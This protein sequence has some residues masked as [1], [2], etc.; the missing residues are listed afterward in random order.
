MTSLERVMTVISGG[1]P[2]RV[3]TGLHNFLMAARIAE[4]PLSECLRDGKLLAE[5]QIAAWRRFGQ[6]ALLVENGTTAVAQ[7]MG[8]GAIYT[9]EAA[10]R[11]IEPVLKRL[12][13]VDSLLVPDPENDAPLP[14]MLEA[15]SI[16]RREFGDSVYIM[17]RADQAPMALA[18][19]LRG[20]GRFFEDLGECSHLPLP[21]E[22][23]Q[24]GVIERI[25]DISLEATIRY[26]LALKKA[27]AH[28]TCIGEFGS[29][30]VSPAMYRQYAV[31]RLRKFF[32]AMRQANF[33]AALHQCGN[34]VAV[35]SDMV[36][37][38][39]STLEL[40]PRTELKA[41]KD[42][43]RGKTTVFGM[44]DPGNVLHLGTPSLVKEKSLEAILALA[45]GGGFI[46]GPG[47]ALPAETPDENVD[48]MLDCAARFGVYGPD[49]YLTSP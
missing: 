18:A 33:P 8:S 7:A 25:L 45:P 10:P 38:G 36:A 31:P 32:A 12:E 22:E 44:V 13:D 4:I 2:D 20:H 41:A 40:D 28:G 6:D 17:G 14:V 34:T 3:P 5:S 11:I 30:T 43:T 46:L 19:A 35:L 21:P 47:C 9:D 29:D 37:T 24:G 42:A 1:I 27:G 15:V 49:G 26:A 48:A 16:L 23:G 39:A